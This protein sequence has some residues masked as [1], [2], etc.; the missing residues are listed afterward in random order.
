MVSI[1]AASA[2]TSSTAFFFRWTTRSQTLWLESLQNG[3]RKGTGHRRKS[4]RRLFRFS[5]GDEH[6]LTTGNGIKI[7][8]V[9]RTHAGGKI[10]FRGNHNRRVH[11]LRANRPRLAFT[12]RLHVQPKSVSSLVP[13]KHNPLP[14]RKPSRPQVV[15]SIMSER[16]PFANPSRKQNQRRRRDIGPRQRPFSVGR[17][18]RADSFTETNG[19]RTIGF[20]QI[21]RI[22]GTSALTGFAEEYGS[23]VG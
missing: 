7:A 8:F 5:T 9:I 17:Q 6:R 10:T 14:V 19:W 13:R 23:P 15:D 20:A 3:K 4:R 1:P 11:A 18:C 21:D 12:R 2:G 22:L 16:L